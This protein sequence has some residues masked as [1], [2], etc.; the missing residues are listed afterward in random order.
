[1]IGTVFQRTNQ[2]TSP[3]TLQINKILR[4]TDEDLA[5]YEDMRLLFINKPHVCFDWNGHMFTGYLKKQTS[6][7]DEETG[8]TGMGVHNP[9]Q[10]VVTILKTPLP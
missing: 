9:K 3:V 1:M 2:M 7:N 8:V 5:I 4:Y 10:L 6:G